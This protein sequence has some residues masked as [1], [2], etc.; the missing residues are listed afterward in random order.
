[1]RKSKIDGMPEA[2]AIR[3]G[4][5]EVRGIW[6]QLQE[7]LQRAMKANPPGLVSA[8]PPVESPPTAPL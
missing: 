2:Q 6:K 5:R 3:I 8:L 7:F 1:M 4:S